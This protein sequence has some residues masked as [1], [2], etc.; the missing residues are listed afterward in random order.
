[1]LLDIKKIIKNIKTR[2]YETKES[3]MKIEIVPD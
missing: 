1:M 2:L 3:E